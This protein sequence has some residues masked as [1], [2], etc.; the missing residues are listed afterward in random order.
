M[1]L[2]YVEFMCSLQLNLVLALDEALVTS[3]VLTDQKYA[4]TQ[5]AA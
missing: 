4:G 3:F 5:Y 2:I 1:S